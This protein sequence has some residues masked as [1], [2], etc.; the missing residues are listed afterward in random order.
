MVTKPRP[1]TERKQM[2]RAPSVLPH[3]L[4][5]NGTVIT[6]LEKVKYLGLFLTP[7]LSW[8]AHIENVFI[9]GQ[10]LAYLMK[11]VRSVDAPRDKLLLFIDALILPL[12]LYCSP[13]I[14]LLQK[15]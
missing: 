4:T 14:R 15:Y 5:I 10:K 13:V 8:G 9:R 7:N 11:H 3:P 2:C 6:S 1:L 12:I